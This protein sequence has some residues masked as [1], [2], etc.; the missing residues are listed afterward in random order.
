MERD[1][2]HMEMVYY[3]CDKGHRWEVERFCIGPEDVF[4][5]HIYGVEGRLCPYCL[6]ELLA[7]VGRVEEA[8][9]EAD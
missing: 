6:R 2:L 3:E 1:V 8:D 9:E 7:N 5:I 4:P